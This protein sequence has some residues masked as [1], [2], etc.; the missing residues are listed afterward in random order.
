M[1]IT[2]S[3]RV[4]SIDDRRFHIYP[5][6]ADQFLYVTS[7]NNTT[8]IDI[9]ITDVFGQLALEKRVLQPNFTI[10][11]SELVSGTYVLSMLQ[12]G[13]ISHHTLIVSH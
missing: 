3:A 11:I 2:S 9:R 12:D 5:I 10:E 1:Q 6:P 8:P 7:I 4:P 13:K